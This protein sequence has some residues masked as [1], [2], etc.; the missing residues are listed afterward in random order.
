MLGRGLVARPDLAL[1]IRA[2][3]RGEVLA[4]LTW[5]ELFPLVQDFWAQVRDKVT[6][7]QAPGRLK[8]WL[9]WLRRNYVEAESLFV[10]VRTETDCA[11]IDAILSSHPF[12]H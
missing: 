7:K 11:R 9:G 5:P 12:R 3:H 2:A 6:V 4:P 1:Q 10:A 8:Q